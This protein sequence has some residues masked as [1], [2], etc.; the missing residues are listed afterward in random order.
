MHSIHPSH[1]PRPH[2]LLPHPLVRGAQAEVEKDGVLCLTMRCTRWGRACLR[3]WICGT[4]LRALLAPHTW[5]RTGMRLDNLTRLTANQASY[6]TRTIRLRQNES[7]GHRV[8][9]AQAAR[10]RG[11]VCVSGWGWGVDP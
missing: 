3:L 8:A 5:M 10:R 4:P 11:G 1:H 2:P 9:Q 7:G 6:T